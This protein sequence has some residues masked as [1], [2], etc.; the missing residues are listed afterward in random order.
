MCSVEV[1]GYI[2]NIGL[3]NDA[4][5]MCICNSAIEI[6]PLVVDNID[7]TITYST[8]L[9]ISNQH[10]YSTKTHANIYSKY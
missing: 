3:V 8:F 6:F 5:L 7:D 9:T 2:C 1:Q 4:L 10:M